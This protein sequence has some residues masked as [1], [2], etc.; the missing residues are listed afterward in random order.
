M[1]RIQKIIGYIAFT[2]FMVVVFLYLLFPKDTLRAYIQDQIQQNLPDVSVE[3]GQVSPAFPPGL[4]LA[5]ILWEH[6]DMPLVTARRA[7]IRPAL[8]KLLGS[9]KVINFNLETSQGRIDGRGIL[10]TGKQGEVSVD[11]DIDQ[12]AL[13]EIAALRAIPDYIISGLLS[14]TIN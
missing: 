1:G 8:L 14:G 12:I 7:T 4:K 11:A 13:Q 6:E 5:D 9:E 2:G 10:R 3:I